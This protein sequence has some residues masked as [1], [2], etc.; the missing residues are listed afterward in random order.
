[1]SYILYFV[2][3]DY[4]DISDCLTANPISN[5]RT[6]PG[7]VHE[8]SAMIDP[9]FLLLTSRTEMAPVI[10]LGDSSATRNG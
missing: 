10:N 7:I 5:E 4:A 9:P 2:Q 6:V 1:M 8:L 3:H